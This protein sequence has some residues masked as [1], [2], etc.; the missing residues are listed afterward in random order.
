MSALLYYL[1]V[2]GSWLPGF[3]EDIVLLIP[4][5]KKEKKLYGNR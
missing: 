3:Y 2:H 1:L 4:H 5:I